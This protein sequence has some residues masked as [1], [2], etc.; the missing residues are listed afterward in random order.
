MHLFVIDIKSLVLRNC[1]N[2]VYVDFFI[3]I[4]YHVKKINFYH[5]GKLYQL[6]KLSK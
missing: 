1:F 4:I 3:V 5:I 2:F 6:N